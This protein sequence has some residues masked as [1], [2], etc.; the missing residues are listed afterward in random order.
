MTNLHDDPTSPA[1][2]RGLDELVRLFHAELEK[3]QFP[4]VDTKVLDAAAE[5]IEAAACQLR[6]CQAELEAA[7]AQLAAAQEDALQKGQRA[8]AYARIFAQDQPELLARV[9]AVELRGASVVSASSST[10]S[11]A[12]A[13]PRR[14]GRPPKSASTTLFGGSGDDAAPATDEAAP[15]P[16][17]A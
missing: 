9:D 12:P 15:A 3:V 2:P 14:R 7:R 16:A 4:G 8:L 17:Q 6:R 13:A 10:L 5:R 1:T 11:A